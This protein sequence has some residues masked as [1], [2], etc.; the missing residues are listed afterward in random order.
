MEKLNN[1]EHLNCCSFPGPKTTIITTKYI[2]ENVRLVYK[3]CNH[4]GGAS[5]SVTEE[6]N[7]SVQKHSSRFFQTVEF[8]IGGG[9]KP[10][11]NQPAQ[12]FL[13]NRNETFIRNNLRSRRVPAIISRPG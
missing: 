3:K 8:I 7:V 6:S 13:R 5:S 4:S 11:R 2:H 9:I 1:C 10:G 12:L